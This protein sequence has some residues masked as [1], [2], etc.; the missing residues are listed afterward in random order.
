MAREHIILDFIFDV[1]PDRDRRG[2]KVHVIHI[3]NICTENSV[4]DMFIDKNQISLRDLFNNLDGDSRGKVDYL[5]CEVAGTLLTIAALH[6]YTNEH[7]HW[8]EEDCPLLEDLEEHSEVEFNNVFNASLNQM[9][10]YLFGRHT[11]TDEFRSSN[12]EAYEDMWEVCE[13]ILWTIVMALTSEVE[14]LHHLIDLLKC[15]ERAYPVAYWDEDALL[16]TLKSSQE[17]LSNEAF[18]NMLNRGIV[19]EKRYYRNDRSRSGYRSVS[20]GSRTRR[21]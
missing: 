14:E 5:D 19:D 10:S 20:T 21:Q 9:C 2:R 11:L 18:F 6:S 7:E 3:D 13:N 12:Y 1:T 17:E 4:A 15:D 16:V 8:E